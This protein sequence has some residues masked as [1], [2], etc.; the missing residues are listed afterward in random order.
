MNIKK[1]LKFLSELKENNNRNWFNENK[2]IYNELRN[3]F[4][5]MVQILIDKIS[6]FDSDVIGLNT[7]DCVFRIYRDIRFS[8]DKSPYKTNFGAFIARGGRKI[9]RAGYY[10]HFEPSECFLAGGIYRPSNDI[11]KKIRSEIYYNIDEFIG[12]IEDKTFKRYFKNIDGE[13]L[14]KVPAG[15]P[16]DFEYSDLLKY[17]SYNI[18]YDM[19]EKFLNDR[20]LI[21]KIINVFKLMY[22]FNKFINDAIDSDKI[23]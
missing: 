15:F 20:Q 4:L 8:L 11:L 23:N 6:E 2:N 12:I 10:V 19:D 1:L 9:E 14:V 18:V 16:V 17:K 3:E 7:E 21:E 5:I 22:P 13:K